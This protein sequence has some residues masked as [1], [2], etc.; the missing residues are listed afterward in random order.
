MLQGG[1]LAMQ[2]RAV[3]GSGKP[4]I[5]IGFHTG[6]F[7]RSYWNFEQCSA[8][9]QEH[10]VHHIECGVVGGATWLHGLGYL[11]HIALWEDPVLMRKKLDRYGVEL[12][13]IDAAFPLSRPEGGSIG[14][15]YVIDSLGQ[16]GGLSES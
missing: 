13:Q 7:N 8:W 3:S 16:T 14:L 11:P 9:A 15:Q 1:V 6:A 10:D 5:E 4:K 12:S 2:A